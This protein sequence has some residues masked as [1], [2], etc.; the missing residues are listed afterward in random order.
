MD[1]PRNR[2]ICTG[3]ALVHR[4]RDILDT[5]SSPIS[6][7]SS[8]WSFFESV[9]FIF[10]SLLTIGYGDF[11]VKSNAGRPVFVFWVMLAVPT[12]TILIA[13]MGATV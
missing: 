13:S 8:P 5:E 1:T 12:M 2:N 10:I 4:R 3:F 11:S 6:L 7:Q 9:Y